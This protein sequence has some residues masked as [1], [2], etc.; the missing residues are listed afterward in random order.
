MTRQTDALRSFHQL[1]PQALAYGTVV[2]AMSLLMPLAAASLGGDS[3]AIGWVVGCRGLGHVLLVLPVAWLVDRYGSGP[4]LLVS[5]V[6]SA[7]CMFALAATPTFSYLG[8]LALLEGFTCS[9][10][11]TALNSWFFECATDVPKE[12]I[13]W[14]KGATSLGVALLG[15]ATASAMVFRAGLNVAFLGI[16]VVVILSCV[17]LASSLTSARYCPPSVTRRYF[18]E[19]WQTCRQPMVCVICLAEAVS[20]GFMTSYRTLVIVLV[21]QV[22]QLSR[23]WVPAVI[24]P[25]GIA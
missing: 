1:V 2:G 17:K 7:A 13:G 9:S 22:W 5:S 15:P 24:L 16:G 4:V 11:L 21:V 23:S 6:A 12:R 18:V 25:F 19:I 8:T 14:Y 10:R 20:V 3:A